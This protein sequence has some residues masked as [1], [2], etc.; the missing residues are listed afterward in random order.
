MELISKSG[1]HVADFSLA[2]KVPASWCS[3]TCEFLFTWVWQD[4]WCASNQKNTAR[5][6]ECIQ[7]CICD[8]VTWEHNVCFVRKYSFAGLEEA[9]NH[10]GKTHVA[11]NFKIQ[12]SARN[13][14]TKWAQKWTLPQSSLRWDHS[15]GQHFDCSLVRLWSTGPG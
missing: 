4:L 12:N 3:C 9:S 8:Y 2:P 6:M 15:L 7:L 14:K 10:A 13:W 5:V 1:V 11:R